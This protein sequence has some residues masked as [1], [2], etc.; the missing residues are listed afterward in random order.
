MPGAAFRH[1]R[2]TTLPVATLTV[3]LAVTLAAT[4]AVLETHQQAAIPALSGWNDGP[5]QL[6]AYLPAMPGWALADDA[7]IPEKFEPGFYQKV[8]DLVASQPR[9]ESTTRSLPPQPLYHD[10]VILVTTHDADG[11]DV[12]DAN[13]KAVAARLAENGA[14][15]V[16]AAK[17][18]PFVTAS[19][20]VDAINLVSLYG[21]VFLMGDS[22]VEMVP[23]LDT[24]RLTVNVTGAHMDG[25]RG[26]GTTVALIDTGVNHPSINGKTTHFRCDATSCTE[27]TDLTG[28]NGSDGLVT[29]GTTVAQVAAGSKGIAPEADLLDLNGIGKSISFYHAL[30]LAITRKADVVNVS[31]S[32]L[33]SGTSGCRPNRVS[34]H[35]A[36]EAINQG[37][38]IV[39]IT[40]NS[41]LVNGRSTYQTVDNPGC[42]TG[43]LTVGGI[44]DRGNDHGM[45]PESGRGPVFYTIGGAP[46]LKPEMAAPASA[47]IIPGAYVSD[48]GQ[49]LTSSGTSNAAPMVAGA[50]ALLRE[51]DGELDAREL[52]AALLVGANWTGPVPCT[53]VQ[54]KASNAADGCSHAR[55]PVNHTEANDQESLGILNNVGFGVLNAGQSLDYVRD[56]GH[57]VS[58]SIGA[59]QTMTY[60]L[61]VDGPDRPAKVILSWNHPTELRFNGAITEITG[62]DYTVLDLGLEVACPGMDPITADSARQ[63]N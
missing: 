7:G 45:Y 4:G 43:V 1:L 27:R 30:D 20:P 25:N 14:R 31:V 55:Q 17:N 40:G 53:S 49:T 8:Q 60:W 13:K 46:L 6:P 28:L 23:A 58:G 39:G 44:D 47:I 16:H 37:M 18:L 63:V 15:N 33:V 26:A 10:I 50:A 38:L 32:Y 52:K 19:V 11:N 51:A 24:A 2:R 54:F 48:N 12:S 41:A 22:Q 34:H 57:V 9:Q 56:G 21:E 59:N 35:V 62:T 29:H 61:K 3:L 36:N 42:A 5:G